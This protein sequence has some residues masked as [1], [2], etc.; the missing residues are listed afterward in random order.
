MKTTLL[1]DNLHIALSSIRSNLLR[2][3]LTILIITIGITALVGTLTAVSSIQNAITSKFSDMGANTF[4]IESRGSNIRIGKKAMRQKNYSYISFREAQQFKEEYNFPAITAI[5]HQATGI[6]TVKH[7]SLKTNPNVTVT[8]I[9]EN[10]LEVAGYSLEEGRNFTRTEVEAGR[11]LALIG[12]D[13]KKKL[14]PGTRE[15]VGKMISI[16]GIRYMVAGILEEKGTGFGRESDNVV[17][18]PVTNVRQ[19]FSQANMSFSINVKV[20]DPKLVD[21]AIAEATGLFRNV[22]GLTL[23]YEDNFNINKSDN[24]AKMLVENTATV[25]LAASVIGL[26]TLFGAAIG[27]MNIMLVA[28]TER[29]NEIGVRKAMGANSK[30]IRNQFL[31]ESVVIGQLGGM[32]GVLLGILVGN[33]VSMAMGSPFVAPWKWIFLGLGVCFLV[34][35]LSGLLPAIKAAKL[36][37]IESLRYE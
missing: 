20:R 10:H 18:L 23:D 36:D 37:P 12:K 29:T 1:F 30:A 4:S 3:I 28:V 11:H 15:V 2:T 8:G 32:L 34:S 21:A 16:G 13:I 35:I 6:A 7:E 19:N 25:T 26:I 27:L 31:F 17:F 33:I 22:R 24:L 14:F 9:D 5:S